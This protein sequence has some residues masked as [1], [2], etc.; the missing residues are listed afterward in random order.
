MKDYNWLERY[1]IIIA[2]Y[3]FSYDEIQL[4]F[5]YSYKSGTVKKTKK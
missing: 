2:L 3:K 4:I 5:S 1:I